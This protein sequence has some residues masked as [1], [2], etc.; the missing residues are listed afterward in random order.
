MS[1]GQIDDN[2]QRIRVQPIGELRDLQEL[3]ELVLNAKGVRLGDIAEVRLKPTRMNY[4][5]RLMGARPSA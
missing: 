1:A 5:R 4:G 3:R 2:G